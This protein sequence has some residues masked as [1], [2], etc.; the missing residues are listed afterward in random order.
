MN[1]SHDTSKLLRN[2][3]RANATFSIL[4]GLTFVVASKSIAAGI[5]IEQS[6]IVLG[7]GISLL[8]FA[9]GLLRNAAREHINTVE[10]S[11]AVA[12]D[13]G[14]VVGSAVLIALGIFTTTGNWAVAIIADIVLFFSI[15]QFVGLRRL[16]ANS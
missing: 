10:A 3:L 6:W 4:S 11:L 12:G 16:R 1:A 14:W 13:L 15:A 9:A 7:V 8:I 5:G 2:A